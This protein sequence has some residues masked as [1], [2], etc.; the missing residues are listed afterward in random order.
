MTTIL[1]WPRKEKTHRFLAVACFMLL[2]RYGETVKTAVGC[3]G[4]TTDHFCV[5]FSNHQ[6]LW[7][8]GMDHLNPALVI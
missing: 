7:L 6:R 3:L 8:V 2:C 5:V 4:E 1:P